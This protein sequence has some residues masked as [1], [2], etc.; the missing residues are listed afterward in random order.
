MWCTAHFPRFDPFDPKGSDAGSHVRDAQLV[1]DVRTVRLHSDAE[2]AHN[3]I[4]M[5]DHGGEVSRIGIE[6]RLAVR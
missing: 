3:V 1:I 5:R 2:R 6:R 4:R